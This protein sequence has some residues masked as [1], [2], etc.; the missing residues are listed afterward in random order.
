M[1]RTARTT[2][3]Q[4]ADE[5]SFAPDNGPLSGNP[6]G[7][8]GYE[9]ALARARAASF[10]N[11]S[12]IAGPATIGG[13]AVELAVF[14][15]AFMAGSMGEAA[16]ERLA[17][18]LERAAR[19]E[20]AFVLYTA[21][22]G[23]RLQEGIRSLVQ[24][25]KVLAARLE[26]AAAHRP[27]VALLGHPTT[28]GV[29]AS[30]AAAA[31]VTIALAGATIGFAGPR[32]VQRFT[33][34][35]LARGSHT[36]AR[37][38]ERGLVDTVILEEEIGPTLRHV[39]GVLASDSPEGLAPPEPLPETLRARDAWAAVEAARS[40]GRPS[41][42]ALLQSMADEWFELRG[43]RAGTDDAAV[44]VGF[45]RVSGRRAVGIAL[46]REHAP[47]PGAYRKAER[48]LDVASRLGLPVVNLIDT[49]GA[50]PSEESEAGGIA[51][52]ISSMFTKM[53]TAP[54]PILSVVTGEGGSGGALAFATGDV[55]LA[56]P[57]TIFSVIA[58]EA[59]A[60]ILWRDTTRSPE[61]AGLL[62]ISANDLVDLG[63][64]DALI[65][66][67]VAPESLR[68]VVAYHLGLSSDSG[69]S[70]RD[71]VRLRRRRWRSEPGT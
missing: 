68:A 32:V 14:D 10:A 9:E 65:E 51:W 58:P 12:V 3:D 50:D 71:R 23:V 52:A 60:E 25:P 56:Y 16:G 54:V 13:H 36:A 34:S 31:D 63:L 69:L 70:A 40:P 30:I 8:P 37:A 46:N 28:G 24:L 38:L 53:L 66:G 61:A 62:K 57:T 21:T 47:G 44:T 6:I 26:L 7:Y 41:A 35:P 4:L 55:L 42:G 1:E 11:E 15:F 59:A 67:L 45:I 2:I 48:A 18:G 33:G 27:L 49:R 22:G 39:L 5:G 64:V 29:L 43:D 20:V 19:R 17:R